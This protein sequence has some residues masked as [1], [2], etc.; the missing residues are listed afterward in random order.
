AETGIDEALNKIYQFESG[1]DDILDIGLILN[2]PN[3]Q[4]SIATSQTFEG[5]L[6]QGESLQIDLNNAAGNVVIKWSKTTCGPTHK[7]GLLLT[8][9]HLS[10]TEYQSY[11]YLVAANNCLYN[12][13]QN[14]IV[15]TETSTDEFKYAYTL[16]LPASNDS[17]LY[18]Q[19]VG[20][21]ADIQVSGGSGLIA[22]AQYLI[23][24]RAKSENDISNKTI[25]VK[26]S[27]PSAPGFMSFA[28]F[29]GGTITK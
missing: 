20:A 3:N 5:Y 7:V 28:L 27:L 25:E 13:A 19:A 9:L 6:N 15:A 17:S 18:I 4:V 1:V 22:E 16:N 11:Y 26:K 23:E 14:F 29:S 10:G 8:F 24:S 2:D 21:G 12:S